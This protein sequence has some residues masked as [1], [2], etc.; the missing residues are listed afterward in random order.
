M[1]AVIHRG[2]REI[3]G[4]VIELRGGNTR[5][6]LDM[7][8]PLFLNGKPIGDRLAQLPPEELLRLG[9]LPPIEGLYA[10]DLPGIDGILISHAHLD[11]Y[12]LLQYVHP[13][14]PVYVSTGTKALLY[15]D[16]AYQKTFEEWLRAREFGHVCLHTSGHAKAS[17]IRR[18]TEG[19]QPK[20]IVPIHTMTPDVFLAYSDKV[21]LA[22]D[23]AAFEL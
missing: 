9:V 8:Y 2:T 5:L 19:L 13:D 11:H 12:G 18:L 6:L 1:T 15:R 4:T 23:G 21:L 14:I 10:W 20:K 17:D 3:G 7:G 22:E 16:S